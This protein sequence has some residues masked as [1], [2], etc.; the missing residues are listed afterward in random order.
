MEASVN[1]KC[2]DHCP[3]VGG[4]SIARGC[5][6]YHKHVTGMF[7]KNAVVCKVYVSPQKG[8]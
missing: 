7:C 1:I 5:L 6:A 3:A 4:C 8:D 2:L